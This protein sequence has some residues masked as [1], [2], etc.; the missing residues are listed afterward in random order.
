MPELTELQEVT[1]LELLREAEV[2]L[3]MCLSRGGKELRVEIERFLASLEPV[4]AEPVCRMKELVA[5]VRR[6]QI[7]LW[8]E[9]MGEDL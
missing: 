2:E 8:E 1:A 5:E 6:L 3:E 7:A 4:V 9:Q